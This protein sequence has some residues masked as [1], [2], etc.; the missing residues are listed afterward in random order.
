MFLLKCLSKPKEILVQEKTRLI[1]SN[2]FK[3]YVVFIQY[4]FSSLECKYENDDD[5][6]E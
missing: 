2:G 5:G 3:I 6:F 1:Y 4:I